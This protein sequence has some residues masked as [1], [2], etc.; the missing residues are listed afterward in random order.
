[1]HTNIPLLV[2][3]PHERSK[4]EVQKQQLHAFYSRCSW[5]D[6]VRVPKMGTRSLLET[7]FR[8]HLVSIGFPEWWENL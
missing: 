4:V 6:T 3:D 2:F 8:R 5:E 1:M 7:R